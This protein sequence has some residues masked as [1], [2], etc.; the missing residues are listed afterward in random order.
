MSNKSRKLQLASSTFTLAI[1]SSKKLWAVEHQEFFIRFNI[2]GSSD[3][4]FVVNAV[5]DFAISSTIY[6]DE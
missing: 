6:D 2:S 4:D 3:D 1:V 5:V